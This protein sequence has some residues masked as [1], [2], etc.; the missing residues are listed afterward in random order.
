MKAFLMASAAAAVLSLGLAAP[1]SADCAA[2]IAALKSQTFTGSVNSAG[3]TGSTSQ[4]TAETTGEPAMSSDQ[5]ASAALPAEPST[6]AA[7]ANAPGAD[8]NTAGANSSQMAAAESTTPAE[9]VPSQGGNQSAGTPATAAMNQAAQGIA[10]T[11]AEVKG[12]QTAQPA[13]TAPSADQLADANNPLPTSTAPT[14]GGEPV[15]LKAT[16]LARAEAYQ[17][18]G[19]EGACMNAVEQAKAVQ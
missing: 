18:M 14:S 9:P 10:A 15:D 12:Q 6:G 11:P 5:T 7:G 8:I 3:S 13:E 4:I 1:A 17:K 16:T 19:N 2:D